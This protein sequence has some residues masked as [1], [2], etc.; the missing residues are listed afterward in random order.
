MKQF[1]KWWDKECADDRCIYQESYDDCQDAWK[2]ALE[3]VLNSVCSKQDG[4]RAHLIAEDIKEELD[5]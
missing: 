4:Y 5:C 3:W 2:A 1:K